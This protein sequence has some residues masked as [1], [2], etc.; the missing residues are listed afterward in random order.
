[1]QSNLPAHNHDNASRDPRIW[2]LGPL[3]LDPQA[4]HRFTYALGYHL[5]KHKASPHNEDAAHILTVHTA[6]TAL[7]HKIERPTLPVDSLFYEDITL[8]KLVGE[9]NT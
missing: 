1:V 6:V 4:W 3:T 7:F 8:H 2:K 5:L 9:I